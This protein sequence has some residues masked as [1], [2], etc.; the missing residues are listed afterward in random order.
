M[1]SWN[2]D[3]QEMI[4][5]YSWVKFETSKSHFNKM[6]PT[7]SSSV[8][9]PSLLI[10]L[11]KSSIYE[12]KS[13]KNFWISLKNHIFHFQ[14]WRSAQD[15]E[16]M[17]WIQSQERLMEQQQCWMAWLLTPRQQILAIMSN[18]DFIRKMVKI[19]SMHFRKYFYDSYDMSHIIWIILSKKIN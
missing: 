3:V 7:E 13:S 17:L 12:I 15:Q 9:A 18:W 10:Q 6:W 4:S 8:M 11:K 5:C 16:T 19:H 2:L 14:G 1:L